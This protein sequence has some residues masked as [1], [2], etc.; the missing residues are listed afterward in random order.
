MVVDA[1]AAEVAVDMVETET[2]TA[3]DRRLGIFHKK[4]GAGYPIRA[5]WKVLY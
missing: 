4:K 5:A 2:T 3:R 1:A